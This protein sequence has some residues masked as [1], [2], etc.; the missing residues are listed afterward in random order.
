MAETVKIA[1][2]N[3]T[4]A[5]AKQWEQLL[6]L[7]RQSAQEYNPTEPVGDS[8][9]I[10]KSLEAMSRDPHM[11]F[12]IFVALQDDNTVGRLALQMPNTSQSSHVATANIYVIPT[13]RR[14]GI[15]RAL[16]KQTAIEC[17]AS[18]ITLLQGESLTPEGNAFAENF[19]GII[20]TLVKENRLQL[21]DV[22]WALLEQWT[23]DYRAKNPNIVIETFEGLIGESDEAIAPYA[24]LYTEIANQVPYEALERPDQMITVENVRLEDEEHRKIGISLWT[25]ISREADGTLS[26]LT[27]ITYHPTQGY[28]VIQGLTGVKEQYRG[29]GLG[30]WL[31]ADMLLFIRGKY[32][33][34]QFISTTNSNVN[35]PMLAINEQL[36]FK[37]Y[38]QRTM[39]KLNVADIAAKLD[40]NIT[41][42][43]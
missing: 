20:G 35:A 43:E 25:K 1:E 7:Y 3:F 34:V 15:G 29:R 40:Q 14:Q 13:M 22:D 2:F 19:G 33:D 18:N 37:F 41:V 39:Y 26:G 8:G 9:V 27:E 4:E 11:K 5:T 42:N 30:K 23:V 6:A 31:K 17:E 21:A 24:R 10:R 16:L 36:G 12:R 38:R 32:P 28:S